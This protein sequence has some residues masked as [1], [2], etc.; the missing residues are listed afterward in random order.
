MYVQS[1]VNDIDSCIAVCMYRV[2][3]ISLMQ[4]RKVVMKYILLRVMNGHSRDFKSVVVL[5]DCIGLI[6]E[7]PDYGSEA[8]VTTLDDRTEKGNME[9]KESDIKVE[10]T[11]DIKMENSEVIAF[12]TVKA[13]P[14][15]SAWACV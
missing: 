3:V 15:V 4:Y 13:E 6:K 8:Y 1:S 10:E 5:Q 12:P 14:E 11:L 2:A 7:E 9:V